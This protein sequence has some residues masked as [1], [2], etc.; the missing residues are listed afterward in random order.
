MLYQAFIKTESLLLWKFNCQLTKIR[1]NTIININKKWS[2]SQWKVWLDYFHGPFYFN[3]WNKNWEKH[4]INHCGWFFSISSLIW[5]ARWR[6][7]CQFKKRKIIG[8]LLTQLVVDSICWYQSTNTHNSY[9]DLPVVATRA[10]LFLC[11]FSVF[12]PFVSNLSSCEH[13]V[14]KEFLCV[15]IWNFI[16]YLEIKQNSIITLVAV[17]L[18]Y[19]SDIT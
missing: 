10:N 6:H 15:I 12:Q 7:G 8:N 1:S 3:N 17:T 13:L 2:W 11:I 16:T 19:Q 4:G 14:W 18:N 9:I 5:F